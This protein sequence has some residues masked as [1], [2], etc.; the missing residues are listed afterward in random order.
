[1]HTAHSIFPILFHSSLSGRNSNGNTQTEETATIK[2]TDSI[3]CP[4]VAKG[5]GA[6]GP[7]LPPRVP[8]IPYHWSQLFPPQLFPPQNLFLTFHF[9]LKVTQE[10]SQKEHSATALVV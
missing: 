3:T 2:A 9:P 7:L 10:P 1:M 5:K 6:V 4:L 8:P